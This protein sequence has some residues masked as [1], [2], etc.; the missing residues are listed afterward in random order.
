MSLI[1][2]KTIH[3]AV[4]IVLGSIITI[5]FVMQNKKLKDHIEEL[6][7]KIE[8]QEDIIKHHDN[9]IMKM[10]H[11]INTL[12]ETVQQLSLLQQLNQTQFTTEP[13]FQPSS[14]ENLIPQTRIFFTQPNKVDETQNVKV[15]EIIDEDKDENMEVEEKQVVE[16]EIDVDK[17]SKESGAEEELDDALDKEL[18]EELKELENELLENTPHVEKEVI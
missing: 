11:T 14:F 16:H 15:E 1:N 18:D 4:E 8:Q 7:G 9:L 17:K 5:F 2:S 10:M 3:I 6:E 13:S 12:T